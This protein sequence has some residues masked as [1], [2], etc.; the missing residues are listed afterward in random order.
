MVDSAIE[1]MRAHL[2]SGESANTH[3]LFAQSTA[4]TELVGRTRATV[5]RLLGA[6]PEGIVFGANMTTLTFALTR[7]I[8]RTLGPDDEIVGTRLDHDANVT[9]WRLA[10]RDAGATFTFAAF[11]PATGRLP[12]QAVIDA[13][14]PRTRWLAITGA[15]NAL[16]TMPDLPPIVAAAHSVGAK[17]L[18]DAVHLAPHRPIDIALIGCDALVTSSYKWY[19]PHAGI[20]WLSPE[21]RGTLE[22]YKVR[23]ASDTPP[24]RW[25]TGT[26]AFEAIAGI[27]A[28]A[29]FLLDQ[30]MD[31]VVRAESEVFA[32]LLSGLQA[33]PRVRLYGPNGAD[34]LEGRTP[35]AAF[36]VGGLHPDHVAAAL[37]SEQIAVWS[38]DYYAVEVM[39]SLGLADSGGAVRVGVSRYTDLTDVERLLSTLAQLG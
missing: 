12:T 11:D 14:G 29:D 31:Q 8:A 6:D 22:P 32:A 35:T 20:L 23:P 34:A 9:P 24:E 19:G 1:A 27:G 10:A 3:G 15:S 30:G 36:T 17:V 21:L 5:A 37:A 13:L 16:G 18:V 28:A 39:A 2:A 33:L 26:A 4:T 7:S 38:G 25:E